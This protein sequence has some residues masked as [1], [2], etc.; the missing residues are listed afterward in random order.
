[1]KRRCHE[2]EKKTRE[3]VLSIEPERDTQVL[4]PEPVPLATLPRAESVASIQID[5]P[6]YR[7]QIIDED[8][9]GF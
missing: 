6:S 2:F 5:S 8:T 1:M 9:I 4:P 3:S 7:E